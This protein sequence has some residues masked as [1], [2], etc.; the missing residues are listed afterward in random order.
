MYKPLSL[1]LKN[2]D[3]LLVGILLFIELTRLDHFTEMQSRLPNNIIQIVK[4]IG[5]ATRDRFDNICK[6]VLM[7][8]NLF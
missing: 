3:F 1:N 4:S 2:I 7:D 8:L 6:I 5:I